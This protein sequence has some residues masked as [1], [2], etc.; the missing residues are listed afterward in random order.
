MFGAT[1]L[2]T[3]EP[4]PMGSANPLALANAPPQPGQPGALPPGSGDDGEGGGDA[5]DE[6]SPGGTTFGRGNVV[7]PRTIRLKMDAPITEIRGAVEGTTVKL[8]LPGRRNIEP[9]LPLLKRDH[10]IA[11][12]KAV[13]GADGVEVSIT[14]KEKVPAFL[15]RANK[16]MLEIDLG[17]ELKPGEDAGDEVADNK[18]H[19]KKHGTSANKGK[20]DKHEKHDGKKPHKKSKKKDKDKD[21]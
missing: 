2:S 17:K 7:K 11:A 3:T 12:I 20:H 13:P 1:P 14:F 4:A 19:G 9:A 5:G 15:A 8:S 18:K 6:K 16:K 10:R 21:D